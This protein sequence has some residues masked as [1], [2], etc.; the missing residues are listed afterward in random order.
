MT[1]RCMKLAILLLLASLLSGCWSRRELNELA[2]AAA[3]G[4]DQAPR[5][6]NISAQIVN[7]G[8][9]AKASGSGRSPVITFTTPGDTVLQ[10]LRRM[11][12]ESPRRIYGSHVRVL[13][14]G[15]ELAR[16]GLGGVLDIL[17]RDVEMRTDFYIVI[18]RGGKAMD[19]LETFTTLEKIPANKLFTSLEMSDKNWAATGKVTLGEL[20]DDITSK[21]KNPVLT[22]IEIK[23]DEAL[24]KRKE[25]MQRAKIPAELIYS[26]MA[27][28][29]SDKLVGWF[30][31]SE[32][33]G[34]NYLKGTV[35]ST[36]INIPWPDGSRIGVELLRTKR[37][38]KVEWK[39]GKP[40]A[41]VK[42]TAEGEVG[43]VQ[44]TA[45][46]RNPFVLREMRE[47]T[48]ADVR[49]RIRSAVRRAQTEFHS[50]VF[51]FGEALHR[52]S[53]RKWKEVED[54]WHDELFPKLD[55]EV[56]VEVTIKRMGNTNQSILRQ[57]GG[58][59]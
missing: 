19:I 27:V 56:Q 57:M 53:P 55:L 46:I 16:K 41:H 35:H 50:D 13:V 23:G 51:G 11:T 48:E 39:D 26:D 59:S 30:N 12:K 4:F 31:E 40:V 20:L 45:D 29:K 36:I 6:Y 44:S 22:G 17:A 2:I 58:H 3:L 38:I 32:S 18:A 49:N 9:I 43:E 25:N 28:L 24:G 7:P 14:L 34:Y 15:E 52:S 54:R 37:K 21:G 10:G 47:K 8:E 5:G 33:K 1:I 42:L